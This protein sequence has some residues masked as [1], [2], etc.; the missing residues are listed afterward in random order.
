MPGD[1]TSEGPAGTIGM[2]D[3]RLL[4][5]TVGEREPFNGP[6]YLGDTSSCARFNRAIVV[7][8]NER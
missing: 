3:E 2:T 1:D 7:P 5:I 8:H 4:A 6:I